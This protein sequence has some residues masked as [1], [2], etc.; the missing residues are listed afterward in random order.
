MKKTISI[1]ILS[2][3]LLTSCTEN[4]SNGN[5]VGLI[6][7]FSESG[8]IYK[9]WEGHLN[10]TQTGMNSA[11]GWDFSIDNDYPDYNLISTLDSALRYGFKV[12]LKYHRV[13]GKN[14][15]GNRGNTDF[16]VTGCKVLQRNISAEGINIVNYK[17]SIIGGIK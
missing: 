17:D 15:F 4:Y 11:N 10:M 3:I 5:R 2:V 7:Q 9:S 13:A 8:Y 1:L 14:W 6:N 12:E 16:F